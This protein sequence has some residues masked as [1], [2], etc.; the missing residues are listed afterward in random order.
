[1]KISTARL[2]L[3]MVLAAPC[4]EAATVQIRALFQPDPAQPQKN[5]FINKT[6]NS[7]Y[8]AS[9]P[10][11]CSGI[12][13]IRHPVRFGPRA[14]EAN[15]NVSI[16]VPADWRQLTVTN[17]ETQKSET[18]E[19]RIT[20]IGSQYLLGSSAASLTGVTDA[21][22]AHRALWGSTWVNAPSPCVYSG[23]GFLSGSNYS[24]FWKTPREAAC[25]KVA[26][27]RIPSMSF[28]A[29][30]FAYE[31]RTPNPLNMTNGTYTGAINYRLGPGADFD[32]GGFTATD[33]ALTL[34]FV[35]EVQHTLKVEIPP[36]GNKVS[37]EPL[38]GWQSWTEQGRKPTRIFRDQ[39]FYISASSRFKIMILCDSTGGSACRLRDS[40]SGAVTEVEALVSLPNGLTHSVAPVKRARLQHGV[41]L[42]PIQPSLY[43]DRQF[44][45]LHF[46]MPKT[47]IDSLLRPG[48]SGMFSGNITV[49]WDS[50]V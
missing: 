13:S 11:Q 15:A 12:F 17:R 8:C 26:R 45:T 7:G 36:G 35:L 16:Q 18:V 6:P 42:G 47:A 27:I 38:G 4:A 3:L 2:A 46:E 20:G 39:N 28:N 30:D 23:Y 31:L 19:V 21:T 43:I 24:F 29:L 14:I 32:L 22:A 9:Y 49:I 25:T 34:N 41:W 33:S 10:T 5:V 44:G 37:L 50:E 40:T 1:M 48:A